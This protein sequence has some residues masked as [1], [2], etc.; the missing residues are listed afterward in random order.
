LVH[1]LDNIISLENLCLAWQEFIIGKKMKSDVQVFARNLMDNIVELHSDLVNRIYQHGSYESFFINDPKRR[2]IHKASV[3]DRLLHHAIYR[4]LLEI[5]GQYIPDKDIM[6]LLENIVESY[7]SVILNPPRRINSVKDPLSQCERDS[8]SSAQNDSE[9]LDSRFRGNDKR[10]GIP[11]CLG[12]VGMTAGY[13]SI[14]TG[15][16]IGRFSVLLNRNCPT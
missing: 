13:T 15:S 16:T 2:H 3:R 6:W 12:R 4:I 10:T 8:S 14:T 7:H 9:P 11:P 1:T 5:L